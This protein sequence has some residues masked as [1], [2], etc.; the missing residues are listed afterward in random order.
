L[1]LK[2]LRVAHFPFS[3]APAQTLRT[4]PR[5]PS[6][7]LGTPLMTC[8]PWSSGLSFPRGSCL[9][10]TDACPATNSAERRQ[11]P[12]E[13][14]PP[15]ARTLSPCAIKSEHGVPRAH[16]NRTRN[17][18][19][20]AAV[21]SCDGAGRAATTHS[22]P[23]VGD[24]VQGGNSGES[25]CRRLARLPWVRAGDPHGRFN[26]SS[27]VKS[28]PGRVPPSDHQVEAA[29][30]QKLTQSSPPLL[31]SALHAWPLMFPL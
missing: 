2:S 23:T 29:V 4:D 22:M 18:D 3:R 14:R 1:G 5:V 11:T 13:P 31:V 26:Y 19:D 17:L 24:R 7:F 10:A 30:R 6:C 27:E 9:S 21:N 20:L 16:P 8:G 12:R 15:H 25:L 28:P